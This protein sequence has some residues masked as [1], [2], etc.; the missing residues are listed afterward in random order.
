MYYCI[1]CHV[2][3][4]GF[5]AAL[6]ARFVC[7]T[8]HC[9]SFV[10][11]RHQVVCASQ[12]D[13]RREP[14]VACIDITFIILRLPLL[15]RCHRGTTVGPCPRAIQGAAGPARAAGHA[16]RAPWG[17]GA[18]RGG[19]V[20]RR[21]IFNSRSPRGGPFRGVRVKA[22]ARHIKQLQHKQPHLELNAP[23]FA[24]P[25]NPLATAHSLLR[26]ASI[27]SSCRMSQNLNQL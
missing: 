6:C 11:S 4:S 25:S 18:R 21:K 2:P 3:L 27:S 10:P 26:F 24:P 22:T 7:S 1:R 15:S 13:G 5:E 14:Q 16:G 12:R 8:D 23:R 9:Y 20:A 19:C 17:D